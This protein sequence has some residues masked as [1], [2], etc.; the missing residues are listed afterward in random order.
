VRLQLSAPDLN[1]PRATWFLLLA[2]V[3]WERKLASSNFSSPQGTSLHVHESLIFVY[4]GDFGINISL[5]RPNKVKSCS[6]WL[7]L[8]P[9]HKGGAS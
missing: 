9:N 3:C 6:I 5:I 1:S 7:G 2:V 8:F 4:E